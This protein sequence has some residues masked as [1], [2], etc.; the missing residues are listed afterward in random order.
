MHFF[1]WLRYRNFLFSRRTNP[2]HK[3][4]IQC[5][6]SG[7]DSILGHLSESNPGLPT[8]AVH[9][10]AV[11]PRGGELVAGTHSRSIVALDVKP[12]RGRN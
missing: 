8:A 5:V 11:H 1:S 6:S 12:T 2:D 3:L 4:R 10:L 7:Y 9:D